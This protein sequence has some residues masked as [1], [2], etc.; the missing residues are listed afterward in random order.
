MLLAYYDKRSIVLKVYWPSRK[1]FS[2]C[3][4]M[5]LIVTKARH[6]SVYNKIINNKL[7][8]PVS[9]WEVKIKNSHTHDVAFF[10]LMMQTYIY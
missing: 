4:T 1:L 3:S 6:V 5:R 8:G 7:R 9:H 2:A 10:G